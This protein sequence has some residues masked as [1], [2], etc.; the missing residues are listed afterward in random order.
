MTD[1]QKY[2]LEPTTT[3]HKRY[4]ALRAYF[5]EDITQK[6]VAERFGYKFNTF[7]A[8]VRDFRSG[9]IIFFPEKKPG[10]K[11]RRTS[12]IITEKIVAKRKQNMSIYDIQETLKE[13]GYLIGTNTISR[14]LRDEGFLKLLR[15]VE[16][17]RG[18]TKKRTLIPLKAKQMDFVALCDEKFDCQV[19]G[20]YYFIPYMMQIGIDNLIL[21]NSFPK[22]SQLSS[23][24][25][26]FSILTL[27]LIGQER[28]SQ[29]NNLSFDRGFGFFAGLNVL[30]KT[31]AISTYSYRIDKPTVDSFMRD[32]VSV[33]KSLDGNFY[34]G[35]TVNLDFHAIPH[36]GDAPLEENWIGT[37]NKAMK[38]ALTFFAQHGDS[39]MLCYANADIKRAD[40]PKEIHRFVE[41]WQGIKG[42]INETL[43]FDSKL[44]TYEE[45]EQLD[46]DGIKFLTLRRRGEELIEQVLSLPKDKWEQVKLDIPKRKYNKFK[47]YRHTIKLPRTNLTVNE[48]IIK[49]HG[50]E[51]PTFAITNNFQ[52]DIPTAVTWYARRWR[53]ENTIS[54]L[55]DFFSLNSLSSPVSIRIHFDVLLTMV[56]STLYK[57][58]ARD[59]KEFESCTS[60]EIFS[61]FINSPGK[62][63]VDKN[64]VTVKIKKKAHTPVL[65][66]HE[67]FR[68][69]WEVPWWN[70]KVL[71]YEWT[72]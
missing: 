53:I 8:L 38:S 71:K 24:N 28:L 7:Q 3:D 57:L 40:A 22:T 47:A 15:R 14:I 10:P 32:F 51:D 70:N 55:V 42:I 5:L 25:S 33:I 39:K 65:K 62:V 1:L 48:I 61:K 17:E 54:E 18:L 26:V 68:K 72:S 29:I 2:F 27:K 59:M 4:E 21:K 11:K 23:L 6:E 66:S 16:Q 9:K 37:R 34:D 56:A 60:S 64:T 31:T 63:V 20:V 30:P 50:R 43:V 13:D 41:H 45:L 36:F 67:N 46:N 69:S 58:L 12:E 35:E 52:L 44:T 49:D 19:A